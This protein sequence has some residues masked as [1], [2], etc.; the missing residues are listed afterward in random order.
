MCRRGW[1][2]Q[3]YAGKDPATAKQLGVLRKRGWDVEDLNKKEATKLIDATAES[4]GWAE[5]PREK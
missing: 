5:K 1:K 4:E 3:G 2:R